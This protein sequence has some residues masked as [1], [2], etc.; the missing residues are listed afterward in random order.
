MDSTIKLILWVSDSKELGPWGGETHFINM[1]YFMQ[2]MHVLFPRRKIVFYW[3]RAVM[4]AHK[5]S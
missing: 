3:S 2:L 1:K 4:P 5:I